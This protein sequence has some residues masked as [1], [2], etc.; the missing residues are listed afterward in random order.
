MAAPATWTTDGCPVRERADYWRT[1]VCSEFISL[2]PVPRD[3]HGFFGRIQSR[4]AG[5]LS[6]AAIQSAAQLVQRGPKEIA[7][8]PG[9]YYFLIVQQSGTGL[10]VQRGRQAHLLP[11]DAALVD[12]RR[13]YTLAFDRDFEQLNISIP[14]DC[15]E[16]W[17][18]DAVPVGVRIANVG[19]LVSGYIDLL[20][21]FDGQE[22]LAKSLANNVLD[23]LQM[24]A[25]RPDAAVGN[26]PDGRLLRA[27]EYIRRHF[28]DPSLCAK[29]V[30]QANGIS[31]R[32]L[33]KLFA[34]SGGTFGDFLR[35]TRLE[36]CWQRL[37]NRACRDTILAIA[38][39]AG[40]GNP[41]VFARAFRQRYGLSP[42]EFRAAAHANES[43]AI[44][45]MSPGELP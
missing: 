24:L 11:G 30:A 20:R 40:Y 34:A 4:G 1:A 8:A 16:A 25:A 45:Q 22:K 6:V 33:H 10:V 9:E 12:T 44:K 27:R 3:P 35:E 2:D 28:A 26:L 29:E 42:S 21:R 36:Y 18:R 23:L 37:G 43:N 32:L 31:V 17:H 5:P 41:A 14:L 39:R 15:I 19:P 38:L 7:H 13:A